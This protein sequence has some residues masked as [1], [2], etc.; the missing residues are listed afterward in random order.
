LQLVLSPSI[1]FKL[2]CEKTLQ[3]KAK[4]H[5]IFLSVFSFLSFSHEA[6]AKTSLLTIRKDE[7][8]GKKRRKL[9][10]KISLKTKANRQ[11]Y[12][13]TLF[14]ISSHIITSPK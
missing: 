6:E 10:S 7:A 2:Y 1:E 14:I 8:F 13:A 9:L 4:A 5:P 3:A 12:F 11:T